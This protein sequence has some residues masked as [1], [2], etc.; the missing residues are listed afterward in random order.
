[1]AALGAGTW[2]WL[3]SEG[4]AIAPAV[5]VGGG[6]PRD[7]V[8]GLP[9]PP[10]PPLA[11]AVLGPLV[12]VLLP[13]DADI[14]L[15]SGSACG[16]V[17]FLVSASRA[18][19]LTPLRNDVLKLTRYL[20]RG[21]TQAFGVRFSALAA[22]EDTAGTGRFVP[23]RAL[24]A[25]LRLCLEGYLGHPHHGGNREGAVW[26]ALRIGMPTERRAGHHHG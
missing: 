22:A 12:D 14:A 17:D 9:G 10:Y 11:L 20:D 3:R 24:E 21:S 26:T 13:G 15:P 6:D 2:A 4:Y 16:V 19:G 8:V 1:M 25:T 7:P 18:P 23:A 5:D